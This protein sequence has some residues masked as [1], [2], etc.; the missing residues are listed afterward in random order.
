MTKAVFNIF[1]ITFFGVKGVMNAH[2]RAFYYGKQYG[3][4]AKPEA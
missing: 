1:D 3:I 4:D 2:Q